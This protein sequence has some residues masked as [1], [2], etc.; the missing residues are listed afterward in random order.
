M[1]TMF[2]YHYSLGRGLHYQEFE[3]ELIGRSLSGTISVQCK[4]QI[5]NN[6]NEMGT[7]GV[8]VSQN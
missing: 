3:L 4:H 8:T 2:R 5:F 6:K 1:S 7:P